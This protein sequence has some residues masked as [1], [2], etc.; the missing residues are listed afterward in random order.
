MSFSELPVPLDTLTAAT[1]HTPLAMP[2]IEGMLARVAERPALTL[3]HTHDLKY[4]PTVTGTV[5][6]HIDGQADG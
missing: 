4:A 5:G 3:D 2:Q 1:L 6:G